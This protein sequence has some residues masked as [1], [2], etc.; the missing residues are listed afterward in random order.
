MAAHKV[1][2]DSLA[3]GQLC[4]NFSDLQKANDIPATLREPQ[5][6][7]DTPEKLEEERRAA[8]EIIDNGTRSVATPLDVLINK[9]TAEPLTEEELAE[10][11]EL[12]TQGFEDW[13]RRDFQQFIR[14]LESYGWYGHFL[15]FKIKLL[16][17]AT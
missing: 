8:Q 5:G 10:K 17:H 6:P 3:V 14:A 4:S 13:S 7:D 12:L 11:E 9:Y 16:T 1:G 15:L 2:R